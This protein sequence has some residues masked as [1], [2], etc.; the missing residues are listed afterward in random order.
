MVWGIYFIFGHLDP[1]GND[2]AFRAPSNKGARGGPK[3][4]ALNRCAV[5]LEAL[6]SCYVFD[7]SLWQ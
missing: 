5:F 1:E 2:A 3:T 6:K 7:L 4:H